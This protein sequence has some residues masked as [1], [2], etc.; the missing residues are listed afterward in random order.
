MAGVDE[1]AS[2]DRMDGRFDPFDSLFY[3]A[4]KVAF[5]RTALWCLELDMTKRRWYLR[6]HLPHLGDLPTKNIYLNYGS[7]S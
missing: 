4:V 3:F 6:T 1:L 2:H 5:D 7:N